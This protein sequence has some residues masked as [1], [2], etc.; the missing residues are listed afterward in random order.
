[1]EDRGGRDVDLDE[2]LGMLPHLES[3]DLMALA[4]AYQQGDG[5]ARDAARVAASAA[6]RKRKLTDELDHL[7]GSIIQWATSDIPQSGS[8]TF[9][10]PFRPDRMLADLRV[11]AIP[12]LLDAATALL[13][14]SGLD[15]DAREALL[16]P[17]RSAI[18]KT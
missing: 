18:G 4:A 11:Q 17:V 12:A 10:N 7:Q 5:E 6:S 1:M 13:L 8:F 2:F 9:A 15:E 3:A 16:G 14:G